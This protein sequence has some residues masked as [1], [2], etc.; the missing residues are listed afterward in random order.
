MK[1]RVSRRI[2][3]AAL[4]SASMSALALPATSALAQAGPRRAYDI[5]A[6][7]AARALELFG[8][9]SGQSVLFDPARLVGAR[10]RAVR[11]NLTADEAL[12]RLLAGTGFAVRRANVNSYVIEAEPAPGEDPAGSAPAESESAEQIVVTG[13]RIRGASPSTSVTRITARDIRS[14]GQFNLGEVVR[15]LPQNFNGGQNPTVA[16]GSNRPEDF[17]QNAA[18]TLN[19]RGLGGD[20][21][22]TLLNGHRLAYNNTYQA[23]DISAI[24][25]AAVERIEIVTDGASA[26]YGSDAVGG[27]ANVILRRDF[28]GLYTNARIGASTDGGN[29]QRQLSVVGGQVWSSGGL[30]AAFDIGHSGAVD[31]GDR[32]YTSAN[33]PALTLVP[34]QSYRSAVLAGHQRIAPNLLIEFDAV[35]SRRTSEVISANTLTEPYT[36][37]G[38]ITASDLESFVFSPKLGFDFSNGWRASGLFV[39]GEDRTDL[40]TN[41]FA[42]SALVNDFV[43]GVT[44]SIISAELAGEGPL[45]HTSAGEAR[46]SIGIGYRGVRLDSASTSRDVVTRDISLSRNSYYGYAEIFVPVISPSQQVAGAHRLALTA[47]TRFESYADIGSILTPRFGFVYA[48]V[49]QLEFKASWGRSFKTPTLFQQF[50]VASPPYLFPTSF[51]SDNAY[52]SGSSVLY[53]TGSNPELRSERAT[54]WTISAAFEPDEIPGLRVEAGYFNVDYRD[55]FVIPVMSFTGALENP[56]YEFVITRSPSTN[57]IDAVVAGLPPL[58]NFTGEPYD[59]EN[60]VA[61]IDSRWRN[62]STW[63]AR[64]L[65]IQVQY[66]G[67]VGRFGSLTASFLA[68]YL[69]SKQQLSPGQPDNQLAGTVFNP[70]QW[71]ARGGVVW[72]WGGLTASS[73]LNYSDGVDDNRRTP[74]VPVGSFTTADLTLRYQLT[75]TRGALAGLEFS[76]SVQNLFDAEPRPIRGSIIAPAYDSTNYSPIGRFVSFS[77]GKRW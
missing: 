56:F 13:T 12:E 73:Y 27:V 6:Q 75:Q 31:A 60:V 2:I 37:N 20:A 53:L 29:D 10:S 4:A 67:S 66:R 9:Q 40:E 63:E 11:G 17:N 34:E 1:V 68:S 18:S 65:D 32:S 19:L 28:D 69:E 24:P 76:L 51:F 45:W 36:A 38:R 16:P 7:D 33:N 8:R 71:R 22:L 35:Y 15:S 30:L 5:P 49:S 54:T 41:N 70:P 48:P 42:G 25:V 39:Y 44:N 14:A 74:A 72:E 58:Q 61:I 62:A 77:I 21:T 3:A 23:I 26:I 46:L 43:G 47:A 55:R 57:D 52:P 50:D 59:P 64:G